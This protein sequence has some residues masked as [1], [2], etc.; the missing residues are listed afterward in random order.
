MSVEVLELEDSFAGTYITSVCEKAAALATESGKSVHF[1][2]NETHVTALPGE[3]VE[4]IQARWDADREAA[5]QAWMASPERAER[6]KKREAEAKAAREAHMVET[7]QTEKDMREADVPWPITPAQLAEYIE[8]LA[9]RSHDYGTCVY[10]MSMAATAAFYYMASK[11]GSTGFQ[12]SCA[13]LDFLRRTRHLKGPFMLIKAEDALYP[14]Y[15]LPGKL[16][17]AME[18]WK[19]WLAEQAQAKLRETGSVYP[20][21]L[22]HWQKLAAFTPPSAPI[23]SAADSAAPESPASPE[24]VPQD[25][26]DSASKPG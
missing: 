25:R 12:S 3:P 5:H 7:A 26:A 4:T 16:T 1:V 22:M 14:Q 6:E 2:F 13:D 8:S 24:S 10:A 11:V 19:P 20:S 21:V 17:E 23:S 15:D 9:T 18:S